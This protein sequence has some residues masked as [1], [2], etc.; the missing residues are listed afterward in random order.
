MTTSS[1]RWASPRRSRRLRDVVEQYIAARNI[2]AERFGVV[3]DR[4]VEYEIVPIVEVVSG[5]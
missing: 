4:R 5:H 1:L 2:C 3:I